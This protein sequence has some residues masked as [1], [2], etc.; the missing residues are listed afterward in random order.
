MTGGANT[1]SAWILIERPI[2]DVFYFVC[3]PSR[4]PEW[5]PLY[6]AV[7]VPENWRNLPRGERTFQATVGMGSAGRG[8]GGAP[9]LDMRSMGWPGLAAMN[10]TPWSVTE[11][12]RF[13][14]FVPG[15]SVTFQSTVFPQTATYLFEPASKGTLLTAS[16]SAWGWNALSPWTG[17]VRPWA[18][19]YLRQA[20]LQLKQ[21]LE[22]LRHRPS[23]ERVFFSYRRDEDT[24][25]GGRIVEALQREF[26]EGAIFR[27]VESIRSGKFDERIESAL[28][29]CL[30]VVA[31]IGRGWKQGFDV[32]KKMHKTDYVLEELKRALELSRA[33]RKLVLPVIEKDAIPGAKDLRDVID[34]LP[35]EIRPL[36][37]L[38]CVFLR[39]D[40]DFRTDIERV[41]RAIWEEIPADEEEEDAF[42]GTAR[43]RSHE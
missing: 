13:V 17:F 31:F 29:K 32:R 2:L 9:G 27:D 38:Q 43:G 15:R 35:R 34:A 18:E 8:W 19:D 16:H 21:R 14:D 22:A 24:Y 28:S 7:K 11:T 23:K 33:E 30:A 20:L 26:G 10:M 6:S 4:L 39:P 3:N 40:P 5:V 37:D 25:T 36:A 41:G 1:F 42:R 12:V